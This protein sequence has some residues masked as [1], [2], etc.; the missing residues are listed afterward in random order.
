MAKPEPKSERKCKCRGW[1][2]RTWCQR[3]AT[4][5]EVAAMPKRPDP[6]VS[7]WMAEPETEADVKRNTN[8][9]LQ[10][11]WCVE[12]RAEDGPATRDE[13]CALKA[14]TLGSSVRHYTPTT[15]G[16]RLVCWHWIVAEAPHCWTKTT[17][18]PVPRLVPRLEAHL[19]AYNQY[20]FTAIKPVM[21]DP[22]GSNMFAAWENKM[23][24]LVCGGYSWVMIRQVR[25]CCHF[26]L[27]GPTPPLVPRLS[28]PSTHELTLNRHSSLRCQSSS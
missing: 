12:F 8:L 21:S 1:A 2:T 28:L 11:P 27:P 10:C 20:N 15:A 7:K 4:A 25:S 16:W 9:E 6:D 22:C 13:W 18:E 5:A 24:V 14:Q 26:S 3:I 19:P 17:W 23:Y